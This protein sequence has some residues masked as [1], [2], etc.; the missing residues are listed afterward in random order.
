MNY[1]LHHYIASYNTGDH[2]MITTN[3]VW[4]HSVDHWSEADTCSLL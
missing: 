4:Q 3:L 1:I 2:C